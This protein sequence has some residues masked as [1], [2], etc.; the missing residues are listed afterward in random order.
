MRATSRKP[1]MD[2]SVPCLE[3]HS[4][5]PPLSRRASIAEYLASVP[6]G[7]E[8]EDIFIY[9]LKMPVPHKGE[10]TSSVSS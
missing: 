2:S 10:A 8:P 9:W 1:E 7:S 3:P 4:L 6:V 5:S